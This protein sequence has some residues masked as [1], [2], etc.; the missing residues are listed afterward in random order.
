M[1][2]ANTADQSD[3]FVDRRTNF[4][5]H[6]QRSKHFNQDQHSRQE[7]LFEAAFEEGQDES[8]F[9]ILHHL[10]TKPAF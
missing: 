10:C 2:E 5:D 4:V 9:P 6:L 1:L 3:E 8:A 7:D